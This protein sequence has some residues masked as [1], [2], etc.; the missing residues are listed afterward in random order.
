MFSTLGRKK[1][2]IYQLKPTTVK[3][4]ESLFKLQEEKVDE[5]EYFK[6]KPIID[7]I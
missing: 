7:T 2:R 5:S 6:M 1:K 4:D 3:L